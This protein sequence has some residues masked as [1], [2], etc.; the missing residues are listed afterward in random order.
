[1][2]LR[3]QWVLWQFLSTPWTSIIYVISPKWVK[4][5]TVSWGIV[6]GLAMYKIVADILLWYPLHWNLIAVS[7]ITNYSYLIDSMRTTKIIAS[8]I[9]VT[10]IIIIAAIAITTEAWNYFIANSHYL[11]HWSNCSIDMTIMTITALLR[12]ITSL[13]W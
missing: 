10:D 2:L 7:I 9:K 8:C 12:I 6:I 4:W 5:S 11:Y 3:L 1:M 13:W